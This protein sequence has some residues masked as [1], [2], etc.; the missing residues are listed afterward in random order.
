MACASTPLMMT[1][2]PSEV[3]AVKGMQTKLQ[4]LLFQSDGVDVML[5]PG[6]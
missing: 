3:N 5:L 1:F 4:A 6:Q 2:S